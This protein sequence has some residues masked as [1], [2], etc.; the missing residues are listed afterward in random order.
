MQV[1]L[2]HNPVAGPRDVGEDLAAV[3]AYLAQQG[4]DITQRTTFG[5]GD[6]TTFAREAAAL[7]ADM[8]VAVG[9]DG[10]LGEVANGLAGTNTILGLLPVGTGN[11]WAHMVGIPVWGL[12][13]RNAL[14]D[15]AHVLVEGQVRQVDLGKVGER[16][17]AL[18]LGMGFDAQVAED[19]EPHRELRRSVGNVA[20]LVTA[21]ASSLVFH[22]TRITV[23]VDGKVLRQRAVMVVVS[24]A[25]L[26]GPA[27]RLAPRALLD[28][29][30]L[31]VYIFKGAS[32]LDVFRY[33]ALLL[34]GK[35]LQDPKVEAFQGQH[36][37]IRGSRALPFHLDGDP[38]GYTPVRIDVAPQ[39]LRVALPAQLP[40]GLLGG[41]PD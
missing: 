5:R 30:L 23:V 41:L 3:T 8:V 21:L 33:T 39:A 1:Q 19:V 2:I 12:K 28:D 4:W 15:A 14:L 29:G 6:A 7:G 9:G 17:F 22:G 34:K 37:E 35:H 24:N 11:V 13:S 16:Y 36:V 26:Y 20:Y 27:W 40:D 38:T 31:D 18:W 25:Q 10:T 32:T